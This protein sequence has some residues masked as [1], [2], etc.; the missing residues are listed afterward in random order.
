MHIPN[1]DNNLFRHW[2][3][4]Y[5]DGDGC[6]SYCKE[7]KNYKASWITSIASG[8]I[9][10]LNEIANKLN[11][12]IN[13]KNIKVKNTKTCYEIRTMNE[14]DTKT[15]LDYIYKDSTIYLNRKYELY[16]QYC[17]LETR[18]NELQKSQDD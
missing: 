13:F 16:T 12:L 14:Y 15:L 7:R 18:V 2:L 11:I 5:F 1:I 6:I 10:I 9:Y 4:G 3:R 17:R 8:N